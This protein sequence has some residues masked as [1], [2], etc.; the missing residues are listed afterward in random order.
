MEPNKQARNFIA[1][2]CVKGKSLALLVCWYDTVVSI[3]LDDY[4][5]IYVSCFGE[6][7]YLFCMWIYP[8]GSPTA[9]IRRK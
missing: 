1:T 5:S 8:S 9:L 7:M 3:C 4:L 6:S 2:A